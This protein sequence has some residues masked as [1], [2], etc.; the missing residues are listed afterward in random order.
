MLPCAPVGSREVKPK[1]A[2]KEKK[3]K[4][5]KDKEKKK[6][7][8]DDVSKGSTKRYG[9]SGCLGAHLR[10]ALLSRV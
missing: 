3:D 4:K 2:K 10:S 5:K 9:L 6:P 7:K 1:K 8:Y